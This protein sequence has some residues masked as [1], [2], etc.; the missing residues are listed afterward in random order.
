M[1][2]SC[3][4]LWL[5]LVATTA[6][7]TATETP[8]MDSAAPKEDCATEAGVRGA[9]TPAVAGGGGDGGGGGSA[10]SFSTNPDILALPAPEDGKTIS[11]DVSTGQPVS[12]DHLGPVIVSVEGN[13]RR[14][15]NWPQM[16]KKEQ[17]VTLRRIGKRNRERLAKLRAA[18]T[19]GDGDGNGSSAGGSG[20]FG[21]FT[22]ALKKNKA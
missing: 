7:A 1:N 17:E 12:L 10:G 6:T 16:T 3:A 22:I 11:L 14:I 15:T 21:G 19:E 2:N 18:A 20:S 4:V 13:L 5:L 8:T 9:A